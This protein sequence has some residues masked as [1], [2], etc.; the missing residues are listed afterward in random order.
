[1]EI[2]A[3]HRLFLQA[4]SISTDSRK[5][6]SNSIYFALSGERFNGNEFA[7]EALRKGADYAV[8]DLISLKDASRCIFV[9][10]V[11]KTLQE[12]GT[13]HRNYCKATVISLTGSNGK[14]TTKELISR[15]ISRKYRT[16][17]TLGNLNNHI[18]VPLSLLNI[19][20]DTEFAVIEMGA[21][22]QNE[23]EFL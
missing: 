17:A 13:Y 15:V 11:L 1:M 2:S 22:H 4:K 6:E 3:L 16:T 18:G 20:E 14:T 10:D 9:N 5:V 19:K 8:V 23:I 21:N 12:L 7:L